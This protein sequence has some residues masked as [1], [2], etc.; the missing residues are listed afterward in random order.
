M[1]AE[2]YG[3]LAAH[4]LN[5]EIERLS[6]GAP[7][8]LPALPEAL[9][10]SRRASVVSAGSNIMRARSAC[11]TVRTYWRTGTVSATRSTNE[12][13]SPPCGGRCTRDRTR[14]A[15][16]RTPRDATSRNRRIWRSPAVAGGA[17]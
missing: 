7:S 1:T 10:S 2:L 11:G 14:G 6:F 9:M 5:H 17:S 4:Y 13:R 12:R 16:T 3:H 15:D 8:A